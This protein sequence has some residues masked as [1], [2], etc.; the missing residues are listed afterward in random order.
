MWVRKTAKDDH[1][2]DA[3]PIPTQIVS[4]EEFPPLPQTP[5]QCRVEH[6]VRE[7]ADGF[8]RKLGISRREFLRSSGGMATGFLAMNDVFGGIYKVDPA[9]A[10]DPGVSAEMWPKT[11]FIFDAQT[12]HVKDSI[13]GPTMFRTLTAKAG[14]NP[15]LNGI[16]PGPETL[17]RANFVKEIFFDSD[18]V[19]AIMSGAVIGPPKAHALPTPDMVATRDL[20]NAAAGT[21]RMLSHGLA[22]PMSPGFVAED[23]ERGVRELGIDGWKCYTGNPS[24]PWRLDDTEIAYPFYEKALELGVVNISIHKGLPLPGRFESYFKPDDIMQAARDFP[25]LNFIIYHSGM[26]HMMTMLPPGESGIEADGYLPWT[27]DMVRMKR[28]NPDIRNVYPELGAVFGHSVVTHPEI[29]GHLLGQVIGEFGA[30]H[31]IWGTDS[32][33]WGSPQWQIE[34]FRRFEMPEKLQQDFGYSP[35]TAAD[36]ELIF[37][38]NIAGLYGI[39]IEAARSAIPGDSLSGMKTAYLESGAEPSNTQYG[40]VAV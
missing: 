30:D 39:D 1:N 15:D 18:T 9:E 17:H 23:M 31:V 7:L 12:H 28:E 13:K 26:K 5:D 21:Q 8:A 2:A 14:L 33:W 24:G 34:A 3:S 11:E 40:W 38:R 20:V 32:I 35:I 37:G 16:V 10:L 27:T 4:N 36:R 25:D 6:R 19:M 29:C 22:D